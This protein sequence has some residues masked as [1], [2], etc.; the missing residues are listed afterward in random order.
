MLLWGCD[1]PYR[2]RPLGSTIPCK[3]NVRNVATALEMYAS[4]N[5]GA[6]PTSMARLTQGNYLRLIPTCPAAG[7]DTFSGAYRF[8]AAKRARN[9]QILSGGDSF[10]FHCH[11]TNHSKLGARPNHPRYHSLSGLEER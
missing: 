6:Y 3:S 8:T 10:S 1:L 7:K 2:A 4:D 11:G 9:G 5:A